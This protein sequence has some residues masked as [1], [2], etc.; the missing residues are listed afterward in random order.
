VR[1]LKHELLGNTTDVN[2]SASARRV[3]ICACR[4]RQEEMQGQ[5]SGA[6]R[7]TMTSAL[8]HA[9]D[10]GESVT[11]WLRD[12]AGGGWWGMEMGGYPRSMRHTFAP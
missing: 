3:T 9:V 12:T 6:V 2:A 5:K 10:V 11:G 8:A 7:S 1:S 4:R